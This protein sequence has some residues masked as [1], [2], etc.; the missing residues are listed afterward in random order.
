MSNQ[1]LHKYRILNSK[2]QKKI[3]CEFHFSRNFSPSNVRLG[4]TL[5]FI[6]VSNDN[7]IL[8]LIDLK[9]FYQILASIVL[10]FS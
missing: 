10:N 2:R 3:H 5:N 6:L 4:F 1:K 7:F 8:L 9:N